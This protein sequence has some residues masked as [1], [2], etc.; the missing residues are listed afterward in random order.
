MFVTKKGWRPSPALAISL[1][2]LFVSLGG[3]GYAAATIGTNDIQNGAVTNS[4]LRN[5]AVSSEKIGDGQVQTQDL[6]GQSVTTQKVKDGSLLA[7]DFASGQLPKG[8]TSFHV[9]AAAGSDAPMT[10]VDGLDAVLRCGPG[11]SSAEVILRT[12]PDANTMQLSGTGSQDT[13]VF[14]MNA[15]PGNSTQM[16]GTEFANMDVIARNTD[17]S[18]S[19]TEFHLHGQAVSG[20]CEG[21]GMVTPSS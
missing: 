12:T 9:D 8:A 2:A 6:G 10:S 17:V 15:G 21:W 20:S 1:I 14:A 13:T 5:G 11:A 3:V 7:G 19:F 4:K 16:T 18:S